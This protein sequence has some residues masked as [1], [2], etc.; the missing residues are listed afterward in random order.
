MRRAERNGEI[1]SVCALAQSNY[2]NVSSDHYWP[3]DTVPVYYGDI[4]ITLLNDSHYPD[5]IVTEFMMQRV[6]YTN[7]WNR[8]DAHLT[9][10]NLFHQGDVQR[11][12]RH[13]HFTTW[14]DFGVPNPPQTLARFVRAFRERVGPETRPIVVHCSAG[15]GRS[16]TFITLDRILQQIQV[17]DYVDIF[18]IVYFMRKGLFCRLLSVWIREASLISRSP[19]CDSINFRIIKTFFRSSQ[20]V[21]GWCKPSSNTFAS[22]SASWLCWRARRI[23]DHSVK[24]TI[25]RVTKVSRRV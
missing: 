25:I 2:A 13:F 9:L 1:A 19:Q 11:V 6:S 18:G 24:F 7:F 12:L 14:P 4:K 23:R 15:V 10:T 16:G 22:I 20:N 17:A 3:M 8:L 5:W 21:F